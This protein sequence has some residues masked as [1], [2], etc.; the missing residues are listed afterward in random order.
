MKKF[1]ILAV[2]V[3]FV[4]DCFSQKDP[5]EEAIIQ[6][7]LNSRDYQNAKSCIKIPGYDI[8]SLPVIHSYVRYLDDDKNKPALYV[9]IGTNARGSQPAKLIGE[10]EVVRP[11]DNYKSIPNNGKYL[12]AFKDYSNYNVF[13]KTGY[14]PYYDINYDCYLAG[15]VS[16]NNGEFVGWESYRMPV[17]IMVK[18]NFNNYNLE[19]GKAAHYCDKNKDKN[20]SFG[21]CY[22][23]MKDACSGSPRC[24]MLCDFADRNPFPGVMKGQCKASMAIACVY[25]SAT[26]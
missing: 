17:E 16:F 22:N 1:L 23:C 14:I 9:M 20:I 12:I 25:I 11:S 5:F 7:F 21:E 3:L 24:D 2:S 19:P 26:Q 6:A 13:T 15:I 10:F 4:F 8:Q 18:Y